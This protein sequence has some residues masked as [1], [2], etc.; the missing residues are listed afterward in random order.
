MGSHLLHP[1]GLSNAGESE[2]EHE[3]QASRLKVQKIK[4]Q[5][6][7]PEKNMVFESEPTRSFEELKSRKLVHDRRHHFEGIKQQQP[8]AQSF[9]QKAYTSDQVNVGPSKPKEHQMDP[10]PTRYQ[11]KS[12]IS[13]LKETAQRLRET[14]EKLKLKRSKSRSIN[15]SSGDT[16]KSLSRDTDDDFWDSKRSAA[17]EEDIF[18][19]SMKL[20]EDTKAFSRSQTPPPLPPPSVSKSKSQEGIAV[21]CNGTCVI[22]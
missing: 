4:V 16:K 22:L 11:P 12:Q 20:L 18:Q 2:R 1:R 7:N 3:I 13:R 21:S 15:S 6:L 19:S 17:V 8:V 9:K 14:E 5:D 10:L